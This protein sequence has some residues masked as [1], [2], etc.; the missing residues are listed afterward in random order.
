MSKHI[1]GSMF[2]LTLRADLPLDVLLIKRLHAMRAPRRELWLHSLV[3]EGFLFECRLLSVL[4]G[5]PS[6]THGHRAPAA[7]AMVPGRAPVVVGYEGSTGNHLPS[8][9][10]AP[11]DPEAMLTANVGTKPLAHLREV[12][13]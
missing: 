8:F 1:E 3:T 10:G 12:I 11:Q 5:H 13:G 6:S 7:L 9:R 4:S 2:S